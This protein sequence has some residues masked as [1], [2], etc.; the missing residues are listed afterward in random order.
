MRIRKYEDPRRTSENRLP[1]RSWYIPRGKSEYL[2]LNGKWDFAFFDWEADIPS[3]IE[4]WGKI[5]VPSCWQLQGYEAPNYTNQNYPFPVDIPYVPDRNPCGVYQRSFEMPRKWGRL[6]YVFEGVSSCAFL[7]M[8]DRYV[9]FTQGSRLQAEFDITD[10][11][12]E[13]VNQVRVYVMKW[14]CGSYLEDQDAFRY[15][16]IFRDTYILQRPEGHITDISMIPNET[17]IEI[18]LDGSVSVRIL[19]GEK[20]L[21]AGQFIDHLSFTPEAPVLWNCAISSVCM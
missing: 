1:P 15:N 5:D 17:S 10:Y 4:C 18:D 11:V 16:G 13:G 14:C 3:Q 19:A 6:Y 9:G 20:L 12:H 7:Y 2:L 21:F 8:N